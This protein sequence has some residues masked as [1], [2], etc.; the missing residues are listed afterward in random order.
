M[1]DIVLMVLVL[2]AVALA[3]AVDVGAAIG[4]LRRRWQEGGR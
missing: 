1:I 2:A 4:W 3:L